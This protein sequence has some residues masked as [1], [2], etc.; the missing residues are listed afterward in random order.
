MKHINIFTA[1]LFFIL[2]QNLLAQEPDPYN[3]FP[4]SVGNVWEYDTPNGLEK[5]IITKDSIGIDSSIYLFYDYH[6][7][8]Y[9]LENNLL[10]N[11]SYF[12]QQSIL[13]YKLDADSGETWIVRPEDSS[14]VRRIALVREKS[15]ATI[16]G[17]QTEIL[18][19][20]YWDLNPGDTVINENSFH[21]STEWLAAGIGL[22]QVFNIEPPQGP[23]KIL[24]GCIIEGDTIGILTSVSE[25]LQLPESFELSQNYPNP[26]N[27]TTKIRYKVSSVIDVKLKIFNLLGEEIATLVD[28][29]KYPGS[30]EVEFNALGLSSGIYIALLQ[31]TEALL[32]HSMLLIK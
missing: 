31:T 26:F 1:F 6:K 3:F 9:R 8:L 17:R 19:I 5:V 25:D 15:P 20:E 30:Y 7:P 32:S 16:F 10:Y 14:V 13:K 28:E 18:E 4:H 12:N 29:I 2:F 11:L 22:I 21:L 24:R 23:Q 27:P